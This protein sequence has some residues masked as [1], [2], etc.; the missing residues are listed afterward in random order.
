MMELLETIGYASIGVV[1]L[2][3][4]VIS[5]L[6]FLDSGR[7]LTIAGYVNRQSEGLSHDQRV[8]AEG[9][10]RIARWFFAGFLCNLLVG[11]VAAALLILNLPPPFAPPPPD[12]SVMTTILR[13]LILIGIF[14]FWRAK[15]GNIA[16]GR[17][18]EDEYAEDGAPA[19]E[20]RFFWKGR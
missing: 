19:K 2:L 5:V 6:A 16:I 20:A 9:R 1:T 18:L 13:I 7:M 15:R 14:S 10:L 8:V 12:T 4:N 3:W 17:Q 11:L